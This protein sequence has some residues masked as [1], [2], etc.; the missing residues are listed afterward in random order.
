MRI[1]TTIIAI[2]CVIGLGSLDCGEGIPQPLTEIWNYGAAL[3]IEGGRIPKQYLGKGQIWANLC[4]ILDRPFYNGVELKDITHANVYPLKEANIM[5]YNERK[6]ALATSLVLKYYIRNAHKLAALAE[7][8]PA[9][10]VVQV[11]RNSTGAAHIRFLEA[12]IRLLKEETEHLGT[13]DQGAELLAFPQHKALL[14]LR[15]GVHPSSYESAHI[16][17]SIG[18]AAGLHPSWQSGSIIL[19]HRF[20]PFDL[21]AMV[22]M[23]NESYEV[24]N[25][26]VG[27]VEEVIALQD[28]QLLLAINHRFASLNPAKAS[29]QTGALVK[30]DFLFATLLQVSGLFNPTQLPKEVSVFKEERNVDRCDDEQPFDNIRT[31]AFISNHKVK[32]VRKMGNKCQIQK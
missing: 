21:H 19:P 15:Y 25:H 12:L 27:V 13:S 11:H 6:A 32:K 3:N 23:L 18:L 29:E 16:V 9:K 31:G 1:Y 8:T 26:L 4:F 10:V 14:E 5:A 28:E 24:A 20:V 30:E 7:Q 2:L 22:L 17:L